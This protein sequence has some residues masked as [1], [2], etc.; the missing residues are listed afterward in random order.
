[1]DNTAPNFGSI[2]HAIS[3]LSFDIIVEVYLLR[4]WF[5]LAYSY[6]RPQSTAILFIKIC[7]FLRLRLL[8]RFLSLELQ[9][10]VAGEGEG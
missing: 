10:R 1:M 4:S 8:L 6:L 9:I 2:A 5:A 3:F 7:F